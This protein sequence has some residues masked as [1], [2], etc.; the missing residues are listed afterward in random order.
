MFKNKEDKEQSKL[1]VIIKS[2]LR[3]RSL[4]M[5]K[6]STLTGIDTATIS[7]IVNGK[8]PA[9]VNHLQKLAH[10]MNIPTEQLLSA[11]GYDIGNSR[12][13]S[14]IHNIVD[15]IQEFLKSSNLFNQQYTTD[16]IEKELYKYE[17]YAQTDEGQRI[18]NEDFQAKVNQ[19]SGAGPFIDQLKQMHKQFYTENITT[20]E[21]AILGS[22]LLYFILSTDIIPDYVFPIGYLDDAIA[23]RLVLNRLSQMKN[24]EPPAV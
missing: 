24:I 16:L 17:Q 15:D 2:L 10:V 20:N 18:I 7:R 5:R 1:G 22:A 23:V 12:H 3:D 19:V 6:L 21:R 8:Q 14:D 4:S 9:N 13:E 11:A